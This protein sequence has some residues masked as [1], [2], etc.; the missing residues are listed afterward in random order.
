MD[1]GVPS[2]GLWPA[3]YLYRTNLFCLNQILGFAGMG[4]R[5]GGGPGNVKR[6]FCSA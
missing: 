6:I 5:E 1:K 3:E 4:K 2:T